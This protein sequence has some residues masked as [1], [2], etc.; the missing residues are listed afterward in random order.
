MISVNSL[1]FLGFNTGL[2]AEGNL[3]TLLDRLETIFV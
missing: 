3:R 2:C 1:S